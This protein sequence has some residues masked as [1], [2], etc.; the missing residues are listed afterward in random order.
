[1]KAKKKKV[2]T[3]KPED[4]GIDITP[5]L[6]TV[7]VTPPPERQGGGK[8]RGPGMEQRLLTRAGRV[9]R[10][11]CQQDQGGRRSLNSLFTV[12][13]HERAVDKRHACSRDVG[14]KS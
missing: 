9:C 5:R 2:E 10:R 14:Q 8:V 4:L 7:S 6:E 13:H 3:L 11:P 1:M 12:D